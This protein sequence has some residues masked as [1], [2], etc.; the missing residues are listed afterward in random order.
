MSF[1][2]VPEKLKSLVQAALEYQ[3][4]K[5]YPVAV[6]LDG[7]NTFLSVG[8]PT[9]SSGN[10]ELP[11]NP[12]WSANETVKLETTQCSIVAEINHPPSPFV[13]PRIT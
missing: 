12:V 9:I 1:V 11:A 13:V 2:I 5:T 3:P 6:G 7:C 8:T 10:V 4:P